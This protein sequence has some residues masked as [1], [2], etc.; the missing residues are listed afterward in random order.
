M[1]SVFVRLFGHVPYSYIHRRPLAWKMQISRFG[2]EIPGC[3]SA[4][5]LT[6]PIVRACPPPDGMVFDHC[7]EHRYV[8]G[9]LCS[10]HN[11]ILGRLEAVMKM[12]GVTITLGELSP[13]ADY[14][15]NCAG[16]TGAQPLPMQPP[17]IDVR[18]A[19]SMTRKIDAGLIPTSPPRQR[20]GVNI[21]HLV[22]ARFTRCGRSAEAMILADR[23]IPVC[24]ICAKGVS[25]PL[26]SLWDAG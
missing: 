13:F 21:A 19:I 4:R 2:C 17:F 7:H 15:A 25:V 11:V 16:C 20:P 10:G 26:D 5:D 23:G 14:V 9:L 12:P 6:D 8:R 24:K 18:K 3:S 1:P 22:G